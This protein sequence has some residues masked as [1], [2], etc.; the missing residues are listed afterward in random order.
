V[1]QAGW[2]RAPAHGIEVKDR[3]QVPAEL[4]GQVQ[5]VTGKML[6]GGLPWFG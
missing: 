3:G 6:Y 5:A 2:I 1:R 4:G